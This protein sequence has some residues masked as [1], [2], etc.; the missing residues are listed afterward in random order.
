[1]SPACVCCA[2]NDWE[3]RWE[4]F[5]ICRECGMMTVSESFDLEAV[6]AHYGHGYFHGEEYID[7][8]G[9]RAVHELTLRRHLQLVSR[10]LLYTSPSPRDRG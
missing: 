10:C 8:E 1:M 5:I 9:D 3:E 4:G 6:R 2:T 7:Y